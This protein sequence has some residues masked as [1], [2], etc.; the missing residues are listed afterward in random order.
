M[1]SLSLSADFVEQTIKIHASVFE[2]VFYEEYGAFLPSHFSFSLQL[3][4]KNLLV[5][6]GN[7]SKMI[8]AGLIKNNAYAEQG[9]A[10]MLC[11]LLLR[12]HVHN[13]KFKQKNTNQ[14]LA[15]LTKYIQEHSAL[16]LT[17]PHLEQVSKLS[18]RSIQLLFKT[19]LQLTPMQYLRQIRLNKVR[20]ILQTTTQ[21]NIS[22][23]ALQEGFG[24]LGRFSHYYEQAFNEQPQQTLK[25]RV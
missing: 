15:F 24:H 3:L 19:H 17:M 25:Y 11:S 2:Q 10:K 23:V 12:Q 20:A 7:L 21:A 5:H 16:A 18:Q 4:H 8:E 1:T 22:A 14:P 9:L 6:V 13:Y